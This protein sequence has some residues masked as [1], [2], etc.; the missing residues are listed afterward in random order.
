MTGDTI[1]L[2]PPLGWNSWNCFA[3]DVDD[4][5]IRAAADALVASGLADHGWTYINID[6]CWQ[7]TRGEDGRIRP[8]AKFPDMRALCA[9]VHGK[10]LKIGI[11]SS[12]GAWTCAGFVGSLGHEE[13]D[14]QTYAEWGFDYVKHDFCS[15][16]HEIPK[17]CLSPRELLEARKK[18]YRVFRQ[19]LERVPRDIVY[20]ICQYG[21]GQVWTWGAEVGGNCW[22]TTGDIED[23]WASMS[24]IG[25]AQNGLEAHARPGAWNDPDMLVVGWVGWGPKL[26]PTRLTRDEQITHMTLW[27]MLAAPLL[28]GCDL[29]RLDPFTTALLSNDEVL[30]IDQDE[31]GVQG[32]RLTHEGDMETWIKPLVNGDHALAIF[33]RHDV[34]QKTT[35]WWSDACVHGPQ[36]VRDLWEQRDVGVFERGYEALVPAHG[37]VLIRIRP[38]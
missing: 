22:R 9:Y 38:A 6:D 19:A 21:A 36:V 4:A 25:F 27:C 29:T 7:G 15:Y 16:K 2:T 3:K 37:A 28:I 18:P 1:C 24:G 17:D 10:G 33:N 23:S 13:L 5:K 26:H 14:A 11:Y 32:R 8:N 31:L 20:S 34:A 12:P 30:A 35:A